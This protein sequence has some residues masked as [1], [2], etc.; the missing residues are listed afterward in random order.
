MLPLLVVA[1]LIHPRWKVFALL[2]SG[3]IVAG[4]VVLTFNVSVYGSVST[5]GYQI[6]GRIVQRTANFAEGS[7]NQF[8]FRVVLQY[9]KLY[10]LRLPLLLA[11]Q[12]AGLLGGIFL[13][14]RSRSEDRKIMLAL[15]LQRLFCSSFS[16]HNL[17]GK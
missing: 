9:L 14:S 3:V 13:A 16:C 2:S 11:P 12:I 7:F 6:G 1:I 10:V 15:S 5:T 4:L 8:H 17:I